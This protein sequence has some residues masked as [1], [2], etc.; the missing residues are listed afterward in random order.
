MNNCFYTSFLLWVMSALLIIFCIVWIINHI[1][2]NRIAY[3]LDIDMI[4]IE[5]ID[6]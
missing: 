5:L 6:N 3:Q 2:I 1:N 4:E